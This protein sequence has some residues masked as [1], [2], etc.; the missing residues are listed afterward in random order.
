MGWSRNQT[1]SQLPFTCVSQVLLFCVEGHGEL[2]GV[3][4]SDNVCPYSTQNNVAKIQDVL[5]QL[6]SARMDT[7]WFQ[8]VLQIQQGSIH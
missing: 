7:R 4:D 1:E 5:W 3:S 8:V 6:G 2:A